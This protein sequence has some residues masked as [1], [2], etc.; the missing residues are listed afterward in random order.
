VKYA[1]AGDTGCVI[2]DAN[3]FSASLS[4][5]LLGMIAVGIVGY[6]L[7]RRSARDK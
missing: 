1:P 5:V 7:Q 3:A 2:V 4:A 6:A